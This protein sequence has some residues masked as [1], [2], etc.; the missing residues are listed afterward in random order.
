MIWDDW[1]FSEEIICDLS[2]RV[3][4]N[5]Y[6][7]SVSGIQTD[8]QLLAG[9]AFLL[10]QPTECFIYSILRCET[11]KQSEEENKEAEVNIFLLMGYS[12]FQIVEE[13][14]NI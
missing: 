13:I 6:S 8:Y 12:S 10:D 3:C 14:I 4:Q 7:S 9:Y 1:D 2:F 5:Y 11:N